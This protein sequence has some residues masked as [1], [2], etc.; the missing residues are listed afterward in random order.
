M[1]NAVI[2]FILAWLAVEVVKPLELKERKLIP[3][4][5]GFLFRLI[6]LELTAV[7]FM[8]DEL[9]SL[10]IAIPILAALQLLL[11]WG[12]K[13]VMTRKWME[14]R[15]GLLYISHMIVNMLVIYF[16]LYYSVEGYN[17]ESHY[18]HLHKIYN[19][20]FGTA[21][22]VSIQTKVCFFLIVLI[23]SVKVTSQFI[24]LIT[25]DLN[26]A[27]PDK[28]SRGT[29][30]PGQQEVVQG[31]QQVAAAAAS[32]QEEK[33]TRNLLIP[34]FPPFSSKKLTKEKEAQTEQYIQSEVD[35]LY[36]YTRDHQKDFHMER[37][38]EITEKGGETEV[39]NKISYQ[40]SRFNDS[41]PLI[42]SYIG[43]IERFLIA[44]LV[45]K[46]AYAGI[47]FLGALKAMARYKQFDEKSY[48]ENFLL[49]TLV[50]ALFGLLYGLLIMRIFN[51]DVI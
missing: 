14:R 21:V 10:Q 48:A 50:S 44:A 29:A 36:Q 47:A 9:I 4:A 17:V 20:L 24:S 40:T 5:A 22:I 18:D 15:S 28:Q 39:K 31:E 26:S 32:G 16:L 35:A 12:G 11:S 45:V 6:V 51:L 30:S 37:T 3:I 43:I 42:A 27:S 8:Q 1:L 46:G 25:Q 23:L 19:F 2:F 13:K 41:S 49:G 33:V 38:L 7:L 34:P